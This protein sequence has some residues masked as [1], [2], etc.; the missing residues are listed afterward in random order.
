MHTY[1]VTFLYIQ[2]YTNIS[3]SRLIKDGINETV[4][5]LSDYKTLL[6]KFCLRWTVTDS[7]NCQ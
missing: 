7:V 3:L 6:F 4:R 5:K 1:A 2:N